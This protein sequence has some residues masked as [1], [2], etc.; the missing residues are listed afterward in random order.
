MA[1]VV[2]DEAVEAF[3]GSVGEEGLDLGTQ[4]RLVGLHGQQVVGAGIHDRGGDGGVAG[5]GVDR[6]ERALESAVGGAALQQRRYGG[7][8]VRFGV[9]PLP[10]GAGASWEEST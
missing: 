7:G 8:L 4:G 3:C 5:D 9:D 2:V 1:L 10:S 6:D